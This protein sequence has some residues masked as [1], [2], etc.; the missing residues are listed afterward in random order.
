M[1][2]P[3]FGVADF[4][5]GLWI[6]GVVGLVATIGAHLTDILPVTR[7]PQFTL[8][9][10]LPLIFLGFVGIFIQAG[11]EALLFRGY[12][13]QFVK[14]FTA[15]KFLIVGIPALL[16]AVPHIGNIASLGTG[17][18]VLLPYLTSGILFGWVACWTGSL[19][20]SLGLHLIN[21]YASLVLLG[22]KGDVL[23]GNAPFLVEAY[24]LAAITALTALQAVL[25]LAILAILPQWKP[26]GN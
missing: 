1:P 22:A 23:A 20:M 16:F 2:E 3:W 18:V 17:W 19:W 25:S 7:N 6:G 5:T 13:M 21:N 14:R 4:V 9:E 15:N 8:G 26:R 10:I 24:S 11:A 12:F